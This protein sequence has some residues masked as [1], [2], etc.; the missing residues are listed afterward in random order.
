MAPPDGAEATLLWAARTS[1]RLLEPLGRRWEH[2][3]GVVDRA[4]AV[5]EALAPEDASVLLAAAYLHDV[6]YAPTIARTGLHPL[7]GARFVRGCGHERLAGLVA[8]HGSADAEALERG[9]LTELAEFADEG[10]VV[11]RA[12]TYCDLSTDPEG[13]R[14]DAAAR[15]AEIRARYGVTSPEARALDRSE[16]ALLGDVRVVEE[17]LADRGRPGRSLR[18]R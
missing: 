11:T 2:T 5:A 8:H 6:G 9:L 3:V 18:W 16:A 12:L 13:N 15:I 1:R 4:L 14:T 7:D 17:M 10:S